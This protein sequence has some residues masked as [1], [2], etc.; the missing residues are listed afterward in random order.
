MLFSIVS[1]LDTD[2]EFPDTLDTI[3]Q[4]AFYGCKSLRSIKLN[5]GLDTIPNFCFAYCE[6]LQDIAIPDS[7]ETI[8][9]NAF[10]YC[11]NVR[12]SR[13]R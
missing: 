10:F 11:I 13:F 12:V 1:L 4:R 6:S 8:D 5:E 7:V 2:L 9:E 3:E